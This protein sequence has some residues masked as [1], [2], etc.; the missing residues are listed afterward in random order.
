VNV[1]GNKITEFGNMSDLPVLEFIDLG[2]NS[3]KVLP[4][5]L[6]DLPQV[7]R[8]IIKENAIAKFGELIKLG[9]WAKLRDIDCSGNPVEEEIANIKQEFLI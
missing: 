5:K 7:G 2:A 3:I 4:E 1:S 9:Q 6:P 8:L